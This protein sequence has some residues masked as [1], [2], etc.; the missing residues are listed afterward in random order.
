MLVCREHRHRDEGAPRVEQ[1]ARPRTNVRR[2]AAPHDHEQCDVERRRLIER[3]IDPRER[4]KQGAGKS[5]AVRPLD[6]EL[7]REYDEAEDRNH[8]CGDQSSDVGREL[9]TRRTREDRKDVERVQRPVRNDRPWEKRNPSLPLERDRRDA[10]PMR[11]Q[12]VRAAVG[13]QKER[14]QKQQPSERTL[15]RPAGG[16][17]HLT[18]RCENGRGFSSDLAGGVLGQCFRDGFRLIEVEPVDADFELVAAF[19]DDEP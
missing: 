7:Q 18:Q 17:Q 2:I 3:P 19:L 10:V 13:E 9:V 4:T 5:L 6:A 1:P 14:R 15:P 12:R 8:L 11:R 16:R